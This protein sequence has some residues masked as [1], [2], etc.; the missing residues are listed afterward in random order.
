MSG[1][2]LVGLGSNMRVAGLGGPRAVVLAALA[3]LEE[4]GC[5]VEAVSRIIDTPP[6]GP[7]RRRYANAVARISTQLDPPALLS[8]LQ[9]VE[10]DFGRR[11]RGQ[12]WRARPLDLD[13]AL[14]DGGLWVAPEL[15]IPHPHFRERDFVLGPAAQLA[16]HWRDP[17]SGLTLRQLA[18]RGS[19]I[20]PPGC[21]D[22][23]SML[24]HP[25]TALRARRGPRRRPW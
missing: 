11:R 4:A 20:S 8:A 5:R 2:Y 7:S 23:L 22:R 18:A 9:A 25:R 21:R 17:A 1:T 16:P 24:R 14:W 3:A 12:R 19:C 6:L 13:I 15:V 10:A